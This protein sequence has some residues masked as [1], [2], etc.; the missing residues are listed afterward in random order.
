MQN[1]WHHSLYIT[2]GDT[3]D[4]SWYISNSKQQIIPRAMGKQNAVCQPNTKNAGVFV[5]KIVVAVVN[6]RGKRM[7]QLVCNHFV[8]LFAEPA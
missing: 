6:P 8:F 3:M 2:S 5:I 1:S 7:P 4:L